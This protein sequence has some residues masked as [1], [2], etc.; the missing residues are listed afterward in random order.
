VDRASAILMPGMLGL[1][2][3]LLLVDGLSY[4]VVGEGLF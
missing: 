3:A 4:F 2:G 1:V